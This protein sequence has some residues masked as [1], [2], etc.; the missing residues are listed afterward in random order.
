[1]S[2][3]YRIQVNLNRCEVCSYSKSVQLGKVLVR[4]EYLGDQVTNK[5]ASQSQRNLFT[6]PGSFTRWDEPPRGDNKNFDPQ[7]RGVL[8]LGSCFTF[9]LAL[10]EDK[11]SMEPVGTFYISFTLVVHLPSK[12]NGVRHQSKILIVYLK[13]YKKYSFVYITFKI[14]HSTSHPRAVLV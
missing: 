2:F 4:K 3:L 7:S 12:E 9:P 1:M 13:M 5:Q 6:A 14:V 11:V 8:C 10:Q